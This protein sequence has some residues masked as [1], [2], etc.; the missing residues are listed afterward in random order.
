[1][2]PPSIRKS[3]ASLNKAGRK[4]WDAVLAEYAL[5]SEHHYRLLEHAA[6]ML[7]VAEL[8]KA[9]MKKSG[10]L[11]PDRFGA[12]KENPAAATERQSM[13]CFRQAVRELGLDL[14]SGPVEVRG[15]RRPGTRS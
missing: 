5:S 3:P 2:T 13:N 15:N 6:R 9:A 10:L 7:D 14:E 12:M 11:L 4:L 8:A 1:M